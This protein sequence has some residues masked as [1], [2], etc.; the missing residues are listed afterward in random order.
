LDNIVGFRPQG[1]EAGWGR[2][3]GQQ[4]TIIL[5]AEEE[6]ML[7]MFA[8]DVLQDAKFHVVEARDGVESFRPKLRGRTGALFRR[9]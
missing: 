9:G 1:R 2:L 4:P 7:R 5:V 8:S 6:M 3:K